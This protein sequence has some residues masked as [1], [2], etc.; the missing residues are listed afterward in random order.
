MSYD[1]LPTDEMIRNATLMILQKCNVELTSIS[2]IL[3]DLEAKFSVEVFLNS[4]LLK[5]FSKLF[6]T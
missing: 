5:E 6:F 1:N 4:S 3:D 2:R